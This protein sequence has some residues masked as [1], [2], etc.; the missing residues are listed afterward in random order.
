MK[1]DHL[2]PHLTV[3]DKQ[4]EE[5]RS[6]TALGMAHWAGTGPVGTTCREC[7]F[8]KFE[9]YKSKRGGFSGGVLKLGICNKYLSMMRSAGSKVPFETPSC[10]YFELNQQPPPITDPRKDR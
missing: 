8:Y 6:K 9:G 1:Q 7:H 3:I 2:I 5:M 4:I 10:K